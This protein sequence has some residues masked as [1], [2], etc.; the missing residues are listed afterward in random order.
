MA[1][2]FLQARHEDTTVIVTYDA[3]TNEVTM[4]STIEDSSL[5]RFQDVYE[6]SFILNLD[7]DNDFSIINTIEYRGNFYNLAEEYNENQRVV[8]FLPLAV[9]LGKLLFDFL[10]ATVIIVVI[11]GVTYVIASAITSELQQRREANHYLAVRW[12]NGLMIEDSI[13]LNSARTRLG[14]G[15]DVWSVSQFDA[16]QATGGASAAGPEIHDYAGFSFETFFWHYHLSGRPFGSG[17]SFYGFGIP[18]RA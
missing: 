3:I 2:F 10:V 14:M 13:S 1:L 7:I 16:R 6:T 17:H 8:I 11:A 9:I 4:Q 15:G 18:G 12:G 5:S